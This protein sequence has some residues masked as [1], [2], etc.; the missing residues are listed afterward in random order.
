MRRYLSTPNDIPWY[1]FARLRERAGLDINRQAI[2]WRGCVV[3]P[4]AHAWRACEPKGSVGSNPTLSARV[5]DRFFR[6]GL[7]HSTGT[8]SL[9]LM[10]SPSPRSQAID[11]FRG[12]AIMLMVLANYLAGIV[13]IPA[14][15]KHA[16]DIGLT[17]IDLV[18]PLFIFAI[19]LTYRPSFQH[20]MRRDGANRTYQHFI[21]R[22][23]A[24]IGIGA[25]ISAGEIAVVGEPTTNWG[26]LQAIGVAGLV[27]LP[28]LRL[29]AGW[30]A[31]IGL[32]LLAFYQVI[33]NNFWL[34]TV[35]NSPHGGLFGSLGWSAMLLLAT[36]LADVY[37][38]SPKS[39]RGYLLASTLTLAVGI[40]L[41]W[42]VPL[43]KNRVS[44]S[45]V[46]V[47]LGISALVFAFFHYLVDQRGLHLPL[48]TA[49]GKNP[50]L[51]YI[52]H[53]LFIGIFFLPDIPAWYAQAMPLLVVGEIAILLGGLSWIAVAL[54]HRNWNFSL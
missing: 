36:V 15:L 26:V 12:L 3:W 39:L 22:W 30:R 33:L 5:F 25:L 14:W 50:L 47:S 35:L 19:G 52:S 1:N 4:N 31:A 42:L 23:A 43:S 46:L 10:D 38:A 27:G 45:Y 9:L 21:V 44:A 37:H 7:S 34:Q 16:P 8:A 6:A 11:Q 51:L 29:P 13:W 20:R 53:Y 41:E 32:A 49:W 28:F 48:L 17:V 40:L 24:L 2:Y 18:A 54:E